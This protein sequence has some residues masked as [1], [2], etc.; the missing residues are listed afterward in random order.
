MPVLTEHLQMERVPL[1]RHGW[2]QCIKVNEETMM[3]YETAN[4]SSKDRF[5][6][7]LLLAQNS[8]LDGEISSHE[9]ARKFKS[10]FMKIS[11]ISAYLTPAPIPTVLMN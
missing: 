9:T 7:G 5:S 1:K 2:C 3:K 10:L 11:G 4:S 6:A 8:E